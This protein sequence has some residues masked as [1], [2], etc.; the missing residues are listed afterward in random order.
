MDY[1]AVKALTHGG[2]L[3]TLDRGTMPDGH[4]AAAIFRY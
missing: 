2:H 3:Y 1:V 4:L